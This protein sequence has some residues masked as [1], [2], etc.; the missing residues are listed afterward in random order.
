MPDPMVGVDPLL[1]DQYLAGSYSH[2]N[3][4][5]D[6]STAFLPRKLKDYFRWSEFLFANSPQIFS[7]IIKFMSY[8]VNEIKIDPLKEDTSSEIIK[9]YEKIFE[10]IDIS[11]V[12]IRTAVN[13]LVYGNCFINI[14]PTKIRY[15][16]SG[17][18]YKFSPHRPSNPFSIECKKC[19]NEFLADVIDI[20]EINSEK[21]FN[22]VFWDPKFIDIEYNKLTDEEIIYATIDSE[23]S[24]KVKKGDK[25]YIEKI[26]LEI[27]KTALNNRDQMF[28]FNP[29]FIRHTKLYSLA[30]ID[31]QWGYPILIPTLKSFLHA[32][33]LKKANEAIAYDYLI[34]LR[35]VFPSGTGTFDPTQMI[36]LD[37]WKNEFVKSVKQ[38]R[39][40]PLHIEIA[41]VPVGRVQ[42]GGEG[43]S[44][45]T[46]QEI[47]MAEDNILAAMGV[48]KEIAYGS[49]QWKAAPITLRMLSKQLEPLI[50]QLNGVVQWI[51]DTIS[52]LEKMPK[53][54]AKM[55]PFRLV[56]DSEQ[57]MLLL[58]SAS[59]PQPGMS[60]VSAKTIGSLLNVDVEKEQE[61]LERESL[62]QKRREIKLMAEM[63]RVTQEEM[64][65][66]QAQQNQQISAIPQSSV[67]EGRIIQEADQIVQGIINMPPIDRKRY[68]M[69]L[70]KE[71]PVLHAVVIKRL[72]DYRQQME[73]EGRKSI[74]PNA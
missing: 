42:I 8:S 38:W 5:Y 4:A 36:N 40:D 21:P 25:S 73:A 28:R 50:S 47:Q 48:P 32:A 20:H 53:V 31:Q 10:T 3:P 72:N 13:T 69:Q 61:Q 9:H 56:D 24:N 7:V 22:I 65:Y 58:Q 54:K 16:I 68:L 39:R 45:L 27:I 15:P 70:D 19:K 71:R 46:F 59:M 64:L 43:R 14:L 18:K 23:I 26:D 2:P 51:A 66:A 74:N 63:N 1:S 49:L 33:I 41:P 62:A 12:L 52:A 29:K 17:V 34:P 11:S 37:L 35:I 30:G 57:K 60:L 55:V 44:L 6:Y 67:T